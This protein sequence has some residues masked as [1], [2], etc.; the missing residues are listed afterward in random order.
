LLFYSGV[1]SPGERPSAPAN[2]EQ[3]CADHHKQVPEAGAI[4]GTLDCN[5]ANSNAK[6]SEHSSVRPQR[7]RMK[8]YGQFIFV[9]L[10]GSERLNASGTEGDVGISESC[11]INRS[12]FALGRVLHAVSEASQGRNQ[13]VRI[14]TCDASAAVKGYA[15]AGAAGS[16]QRLCVDKAAVE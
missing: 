8:K 2:S 5:P 14:L 12:L 9:D 16:L 6:S 3:Q 7:R 11:A 13:R 15:R 10:A 1:S 4:E